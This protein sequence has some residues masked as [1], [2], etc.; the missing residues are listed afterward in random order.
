MEIVVD[1]GGLFYVTF[2]VTC[3]VILLHASGDMVELVD[4]HGSEPCGSSTVR[5]RVSLSPQI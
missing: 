3:Y 1:S 5:V 2:Y 4:T